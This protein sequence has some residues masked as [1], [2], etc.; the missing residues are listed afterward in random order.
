MSYHVI[1]RDS[2]WH[3][4]KDGARRATKSF[5]SRLA[6][7]DYGRSLVLSKRV[8]LFIHRRDGLVE[9]HQRP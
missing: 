6:A 4:R 3:V 7:I 2:R 1:Y 5:D 8:D 9:E